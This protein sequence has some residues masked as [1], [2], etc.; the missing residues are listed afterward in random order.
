MPIT[1]DRMIALIQDCRKA[2]AY[3]ERLITDL[4]QAVKNHVKG[5]FSP[6]ELSSLILSTINSHH[7]PV[8]A[9][10]LVEEAHFAKMAGK[11]ERQRRYM[12][13]Q[14]RMAGV[15]QKPTAPG[16]PT[17]Q[18]QGPEITFPKEYWDGLRQEEEAFQKK[19]T[20]AQVIIKKDPDIIPDLPED[21]NE[22]PDLN[23]IF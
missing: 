22:T 11:N 16:L 5:D 9:A 4:R 10:L 19:F 1:Q 3:R 7:P 20:P 13:G 15:P 17:P 8:L 23:D 12:N 21:L 14:R 6:E 2:E 18:G